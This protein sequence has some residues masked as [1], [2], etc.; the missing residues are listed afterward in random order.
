MLWLLRHE[1]GFIW[2][3]LVYLMMNA[4]LFVQ[5]IN[6]RNPLIPSNYAKLCTPSLRSSFVREQSKTIPIYM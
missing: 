5:F 3:I 1:R 6:L 4:M 2:S